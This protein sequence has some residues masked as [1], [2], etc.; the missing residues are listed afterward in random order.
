[1][2]MSSSGPNAD[3]DC[4]GMKKAAGGPGQAK[5][6][7]R[8]VRR[9]S[10]I[11]KGG[12]GLCSAMRASPSVFPL[13]AL[14][15]VSLVFLITV[16]STWEKQFKSNRNLQWLIISA[17]SVLSGL[18]WGRTSWQKR[19]V[20]QSCSPHGDQGTKGAEGRGKGQDTT[21]KNIAPTTY[22]LQGGPIS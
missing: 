12:P 4:Y 14:E 17:G 6:W 21:P 22:F 8:S 19:V 11:G 3:R 5:C 16:T 1:M 7:S 2:D 15:D 9:W 10:W 18:W 13:C 20:K